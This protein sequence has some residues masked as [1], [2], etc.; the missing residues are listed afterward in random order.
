MDQVSVRV[1]GLVG[2]FAAAVVGQAVLFRASWLLPAD[3]DPDAFLI[4]GGPTV[5]LLLL[6]IGIS[7][8]WGCR[9]M[10]RRLATRSLTD[11][12]PNESTGHESLSRRVL[13]SQTILF[14]ILGTGVGLLVGAAAAWILIALNGMGNGG[15]TSIVQ[16]QV[17][18]FVT[19][20]LWGIG[21]FLAAALSIRFPTR[22]Q[23]QMPSR[24]SR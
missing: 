16:Y 18:D 6:L 12:G 3:F 8:F 7:T 23:A 22:D 24:V 9:V 10:L 4:L 19:A 17:G 20:A 2:V 14:A 13:L 15:D 21:V 5:G 1:S 11:H